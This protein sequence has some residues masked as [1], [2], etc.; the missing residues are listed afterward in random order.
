MSNILKNNSTDVV[1]PVVS[2][3]MPVYNGGKYIREALDSL[4]MQSFSNFELI[5][6]DN[7]S[8]DDTAAICQQ[9][10]VKDSRI[11]Y[12]RQ[13]VNIGA[14]ANF[15]FVLEQAHGEYFMWAAADD[16]WDSNWIEMLLNAMKESATNAAFGKIQSIDEHSQK[17]CHYVNDLT[18]DYRGIRWYRQLKYFLQFEGAGK[19]NPIYGL[20]NTADLREIKLGNYSYDYLIVFD[21]LSKTE[22]AGSSESIFYK[23][24]HPDAAGGGMHKN[25]NKGINATARIMLRHLVNPIPDGLIS[26]YVRLASGNKAL[27]IV[28]LPFKYLVAYCFMISN[29]RFF[30]KDL[31]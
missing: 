3:G 12:K 10:A 5:I 25:S 14:L 15:T 6:S 8:T 4:L 11:R 16:K 1:L 27:L 24:I 7:A 26:E 28:A 20:W 22:I 31:S 30:S 13:H 21:L 17:L 2:I 9:Y 18:F 19:A 29:N 23:R